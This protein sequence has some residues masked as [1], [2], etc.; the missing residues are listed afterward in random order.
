MY[1]TKLCQYSNDEKAK[2]LDLVLFMNNVPNIEVILDRNEF[3]VHFLDSHTHVSI[4]LYNFEMAY[5]ELLDVLNTCNEHNSKEWTVFTHEELKEKGL[6]SSDVLVNH[7]GGCSIIGA[8]QLAEYNQMMN[9]YI[10][11]YKLLMAD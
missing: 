4:C 1:A 10:D 3:R 7:K 9:G 8:K 2:I 5:R 6:R 11:E